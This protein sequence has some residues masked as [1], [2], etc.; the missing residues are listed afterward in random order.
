[1]SWDIIEVNWTELRGHVK[2]QW[3][4]RSD[5]HLDTIAGKR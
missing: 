1:M 2:V 4:V 3:D 5:D